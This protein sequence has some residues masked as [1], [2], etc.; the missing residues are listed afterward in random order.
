MGLGDK[1]EFIEKLKEV[2]ESNIEIAR[3]IGDAQ[4]IGVLSG[5]MKE[6]LELARKELI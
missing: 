2:F 3:Q 5:V 6:V 1:K 4:S